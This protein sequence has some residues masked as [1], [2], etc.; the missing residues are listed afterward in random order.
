MVMP[1]IKK[2]PEASAFV[3]KHVEQFT[4]NHKVISMTVDRYKV[5]RN[6][7][8]KWLHESFS[9]IHEEEMPLRPFRKTRN[10][11]AMERLAY[12]AITQMEETGNANWA[13]VAIRALDHLAKLDGLYEP[14]KLEVTETRRRP[15]DMTPLERRTAIDALLEKRREAGL[16]ELVSN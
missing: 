16:D 14:D 3:R 8:A 10:R 1:I 12:H 4:P 6:T 13:T 11:K 5:H 2:S 7:A 9:D 15:E